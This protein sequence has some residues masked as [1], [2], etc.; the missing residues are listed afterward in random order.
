MFRK[1]LQHVKS[2]RFKIPAIWLNFI[3]SCVNLLQNMFISTD[4]YIPAAMAGKS[5]RQTHVRT[6]AE[7]MWSY[8]I[9]FPAAAS[10]A[11]RYCS[12]TLY[13]VE[14]WSKVMSRADHHYFYARAR[15]LQYLIIFLQ[16]FKNFGWKFFIAGLK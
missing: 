13:A 2:L 9:E 3:P 10:K 4:S 6:A 7:A 16:K 14:N 5:Q 1:I 12:A 15:G 8:Q 11:L